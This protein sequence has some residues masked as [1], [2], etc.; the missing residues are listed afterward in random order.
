MH[1]Y[2]ETNIKLFLCFIGDIEDCPGLDSLPCYQVSVLKNGD[3]K[4]SAKR[5]LLAANVRQ[6]PTVG[7]NLRSE[8][9]FLIIGGGL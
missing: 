8:D 5:S 3:V 2:G 7:R 4:V 1:R 6:R 9:T